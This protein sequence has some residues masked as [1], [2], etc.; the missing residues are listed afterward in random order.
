MIADADFA[1]WFAHCGIETRLVRL[2]GRPKLMVASLA[3]P[4]VIALEPGL[5]EVAHAVA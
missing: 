5:E 2:D 3:R 1:P 4:E